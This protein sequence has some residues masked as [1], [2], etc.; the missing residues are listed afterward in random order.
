QGRR[1]A[2]RLLGVVPIPARITATDPGRSWTWRVGV[3]IDMEHI[4]EPHENGCTIA[5]AIR[6]PKPLEHA[7][8]ATYGPVVALLLQRLSRTAAARPRP[9]RTGTPRG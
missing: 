8:R 5:I 1:G 6:A 9:T 7:L 2:A 4:V 3:A